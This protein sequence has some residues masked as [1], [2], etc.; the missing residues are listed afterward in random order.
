MITVAHDTEPLDEMACACCGKPIRRLAD[1]ESLT[2]FLEETALQ[3]RSFQCVNC[4]RVVC[5]QCGVNGYRCTCRSNAWIAIPCL[6]R[7]PA[8]VHGPSGR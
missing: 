6:D 3:R 7:S 5:Y 1:H 4:G 8:T 2:L